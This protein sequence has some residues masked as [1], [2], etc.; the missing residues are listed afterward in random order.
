MCVV[1]PDKWTEW[2]TVEKQKKIKKRMGYFAM[3][4]VYS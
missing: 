4:K 1:N 2:C 3:A